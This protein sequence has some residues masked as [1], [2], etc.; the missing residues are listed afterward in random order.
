LQT[1]CDNSMDQLHWPEGHQIRQEIRSREP[2]G[3]NSSKWSW[4]SIGNVN[5]I[6]SLYPKADKAECRCCLGVLQCETCG[7]LVRPLTGVSD[8]KGQLALGC[9]DIKHPTCGNTLKW[10]NCDA[11]TLNYGVEQDGVEYSIWEHAGSHR[12]HARPPSGRRPPNIHNVRTVQGAHTH[13]PIRSLPSRQPTSAHQEH[14][15]N[16][17]LGD[18]GSK[19]KKTS[20][21]KHKVLS[22]PA[23]PPSLPIAGPSHVQAPPAARDVLYSGPVP[24]TEPT[25][26][27]CSTKTQRVSFKIVECEECGEPTD[28]IDT[29]SGNKGS[30]WSCPVCRGTVVW[31]DAK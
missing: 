23:V 1:P 14:P 5:H 26:A 15:A 28:G 11:R 27:S 25:V 6:G 8:L 30:S 31:N 29:S 4:R 19:M 12:S 21:A 20:V 10:I 17:G 7:A 3:W 2:P 16:Q 22:P 9:P 18:A 24:E 13:L